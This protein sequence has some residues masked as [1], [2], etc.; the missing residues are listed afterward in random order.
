MKT[1]I[2]ITNT[3]KERQELKTPIVIT[4]TKK[5]RQELGEI[6]HDL[7][8][9]WNGGGDLRDVINLKECEG[10]CYFVDIRGVTW[11]DLKYALSESEKLMS[12]Q[13]YKKMVGMEDEQEKINALTKKLV[14]LVREHV[15]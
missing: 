13:D 10:I 2:V 1:P 3:K 12:L 14:S 15:R 4:N 9:K 8:Y 7:G 11:S 5:E 6:L